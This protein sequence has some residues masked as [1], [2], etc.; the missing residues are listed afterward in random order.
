M[1]AVRSSVVSRHG[2]VC[3]GHTEGGKGVTGC[4]CGQSVCESGCSQMHG[5]F[6]ICARCPAVALSLILLRV[7]I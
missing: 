3:K 5:C 7:N 6:A 4:V 1:D 2:G